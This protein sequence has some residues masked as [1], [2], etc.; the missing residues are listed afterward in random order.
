MT[1]K[2]ARV[3]FEGAMRFVA[4]NEDGRSIVLDDR[5][6][7][8]G[9][10]PLEGLL[11]SLASCTAMDVISILVKKRQEVTGY[12]IDV[13][14]DQRDEY[15]KIF[16]RIDLV[17]ELTGPALDEVAVRRAIFLSATKYCP[18]SAMLSAG[19]TEIH[20][21]FRM[22]VVPPDAGEGAEIEDTVIVTG[23]Y[24]STEPVD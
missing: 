6:G 8:G 15:P 11:G 7:G 17:H 22:R 10:S 20:H 13:V 12:E 18:V 16:R 9:P 19:P 5:D 24:R 4:S 1:L 14:A 21:R 23:P 3:R 2:R